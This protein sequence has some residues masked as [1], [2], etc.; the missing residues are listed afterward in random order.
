MAEHQVNS[1]ASKGQ[2]AALM[3]MAKATYTAS[4]NS[5]IQPHTLLNLCKGDSTGI[6]QM[7]LRMAFASGFMSLQHARETIQTI[8][9]VRSNVVS[10]IT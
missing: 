1:P 10:S 5:M 6:L 9:S 4:I 7:D 2:K 8:H 3:G